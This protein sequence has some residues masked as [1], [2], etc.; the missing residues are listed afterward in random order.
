MVVTELI[1]ES[2]GLGF[3]IRQAGTN[4]EPSTGLAVILLLAIIG[5]VLD[6][7]VVGATHRLAFWARGVEI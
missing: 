5:F 6:R 3:L 7:L 1:G 4:F 2:R